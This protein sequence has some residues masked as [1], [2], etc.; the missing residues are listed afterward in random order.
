MLRSYVAALL[1][2]GL[3]GCD[4]FGQSSD[5]HGICDRFR[6]CISSNYNI[7]G[8]EERCDGA[9]SSYRS[10]AIE[11]CGSCLDE[12]ECY[13]SGY[14]CARVCAWIVPYE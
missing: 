6:D 10:H 5:C 7:E 13:E 2:L 12:T 14:S 3:T 11:E 1:L 8:C 4:N 9:D